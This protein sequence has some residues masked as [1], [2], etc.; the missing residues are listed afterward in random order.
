MENNRTTFWEK[1]A[2]LLSGNAS[3]ED[4][5]WVTQQQTQEKEL[6]EAFREAGKV[7]SGTALPKTDYERNVEKGWQRIQLRVQTR[8]MQQ[9]KVRKMPAATMWGIAGSI[10]LLIFAGWYFI[11]RQTVTENWTQVQTAANETKTIM[12][13]D[14]SKVSLNGNSTFSYP[15]DFQKENRT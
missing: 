15:A 13:A 2:R 7:W 14:G 6:K 5:T 11:I 3:A 12:L 10:A 4:K 8:E 1:L 9:P